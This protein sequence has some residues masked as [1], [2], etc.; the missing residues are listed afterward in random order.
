VVS[1]PKHADCLQRKKQELV[2]L[3][4]KV[5]TGLDR[6]LNALV[7]WVRTILTTDQKKT[8]FNPPMSN[9]PNKHAGMGLA[10]A[11]P[12]CLRVVKFVNHQVWEWKFESY[13]GTS[14][15]VLLSLSC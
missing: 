14:N 5:D 9:G 8:D 12:A 15:L 2:K 13:I 4:H 1:T 10:Q 3:E 11:S 7:G 6:T